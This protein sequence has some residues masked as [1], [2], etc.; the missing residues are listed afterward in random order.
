MTRGCERFGDKIMRFN[1]QRAIT[2]RARS[3]AL[4][5]GKRG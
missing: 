1:S 4:M 2:D 3:L 5:T